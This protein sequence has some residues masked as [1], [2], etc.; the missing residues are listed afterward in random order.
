MLENYCDCDVMR[1][2]VFVGPLI[3]AQIARNYDAGAF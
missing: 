3:F 2:K 1:S